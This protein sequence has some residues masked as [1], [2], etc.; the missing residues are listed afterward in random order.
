MSTSARS[1]RSRKPR[2]RAGTCSFIRYINP[3]RIIPTR[4][5]T[6]LRRA[7]VPQDPRRSVAS[8][9][10]RDFAPGD[11][12]AAADGQDPT[13]HPRAF[14]RG[15]Q[16]SFRRHAIVAAYN[17]DLAQDFGG[18]LSASWNRPRPRCVPARDAGKQGAEVDRVRRRRRHGVHRPRWCGYRPTRRHCSSS[19]TRTRTRTMPTRWRRGKKRGRC[20]LAWSTRG[21]ATRRRDRD[22]YPMER[23]MTLSPA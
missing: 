19:T 16:D 10:R 1:R 14:R 11:L 7:R 2:R 22:P 21:C 23:G 8:Q 17:Q 6:A 3:T 5:I 13:L 18:R 20:S 4:Y 12:D 9:G 15:S